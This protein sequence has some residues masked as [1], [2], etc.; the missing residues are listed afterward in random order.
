[1][2][3]GVRKILAAVLAAFLNF[4]IPG[5]LVAQ[6]RRGADLIVTAKD[7]RE[8]RGELIAVKAD[9]LLLL[10]HMTGKDGSA[11]MAEISVIKLVRESKALT[12]LLMGFIPGAAGGAVWGA[13][14]MHG[15]MP[16]PA[17]PPARPGWGRPCRRTYRLTNRP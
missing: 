5:G 14:A 2:K 6:G 3:L 12:G 1:M 7:G 16:E 4:V 15:D 11:A 8:L 13:L 17:S 10:D 9:S